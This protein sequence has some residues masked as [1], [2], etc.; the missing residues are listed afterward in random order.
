VP[1]KGEEWRKSKVMQ[2][3]SSKVQRDTKKG[4]MKHNDESYICCKE[5][6]FPNSV[7]RVPE[8]EF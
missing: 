3:N 6:M 5:I 8:I 4:K 2:D 7:G 1:Q